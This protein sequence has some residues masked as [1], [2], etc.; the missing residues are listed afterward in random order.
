M[1]VTRSHLLW[2]LADLVKINA[3]TDSQI[4][5]LRARNTALEARFSAMEREFRQLAY[6]YADFESRWPSFKTF[7]P[8]A[9]K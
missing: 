5:E 3:R 2:L 7:P 9:K 8:E 4:A 6:R 1:K